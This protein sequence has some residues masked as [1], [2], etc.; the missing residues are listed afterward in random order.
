MSLQRTYYPARQ[1]SGG[2]RPGAQALMAWWLGAYG[3]LG[4]KN[5]GIY[6]C[7][8]IAG[9]VTLSLHGEGRAADLGVPVGN[10]WAWPV[11]EAMRQNSKELGI[12]LIIHDRKVWSARH[13]DAG[14]RPY[15]GENPHTDHAHV[16]LTPEAASSLTVQ[17]VN[18]TLAPAANATEVILSQL[19]TL[20]KGMTGQFVT[21]L[22]ALLNASGA[23]LALDGAFGEK[24]D[25]ALRA[26]QAAHNVRA[27]V[28]NGKGDGEA[29]KYTWAA[30]LGVTL[31]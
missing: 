6:N 1:C 15:D 10:K 8:S 12:Q 7:R 3:H 26:F 11:F 13:P 18:N 31:G 30:L 29:G 17:H 28:D 14:W 4:A 5:L 2:P 25:A 21:R 20:K 24:T 27:S 16:E 19:P 23:G 9:S 22:Q